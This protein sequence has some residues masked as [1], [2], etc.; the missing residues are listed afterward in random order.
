MK[1]INTKYPVIN[2][3]EHCESLYFIYGFLHLTG[4]VL[5]TW[6]NYIFLLCEHKRQ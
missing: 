5:I 2:Q 6:I 4:K 1:K 3:L